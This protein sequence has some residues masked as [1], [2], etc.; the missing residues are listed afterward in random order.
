MK[1][2]WNQ[3]YSEPG[4]AYGDEPN[5]FFKFQLNKVKP[6][7][8]ILFPAEG[9]GRNSVYAATK[10][11]VATAFDISDS[12]KLKALQLA[13]KNGVNIDYLVG[14][15]D[16][17]PLEDKFFDGIVFTYTHFP[18]GIKEDFFYNIIKKLKP[19]GWI[20][21]ECFSIKNLPHREANPN[22]GGPQQEEMLYTVDELESL[23][24]KDAKI[25]E[26]M[27]EL[28]EGKYHVGKGC[29]I[30][31]FKGLPNDQ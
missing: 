14:S 18:N 26:E 24:G 9:E 30:R 13:E 29:V 21:F 1:E 11:M 3:R 28:N 23:I 20:I 6:G 7:S 19:N 16:E 31:A 10:G 22:I 25:W 15:Y 5:Q 2:F 8:K 27:T 4:F 12:G 17:V